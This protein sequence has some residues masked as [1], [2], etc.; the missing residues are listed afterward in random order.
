M[1]PHPLSDGDGVSGS[2][3]LAPRSK[4][5]VMILWRSAPSRSGA[6]EPLAP[7]APNQSGARAAE[8]SRD[9]RVP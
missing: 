7:P 3:L 9:V 5:T 2:K 6:K 4:R 8:E 1:P